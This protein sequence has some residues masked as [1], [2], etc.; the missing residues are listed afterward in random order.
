MADF[1]IRFFNDLCDDSGH[2]HAVCQRNLL[3][4]DAGTSEEAIKA[5]QSAF[6]LLEDVPEWTIRAQ[7]FEIEPIASVS[8][9]CLAK[10]TD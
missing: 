6:A 8:Q 9:A 7:R 3:I 2:E 4:P 10:T 1:R 5:A